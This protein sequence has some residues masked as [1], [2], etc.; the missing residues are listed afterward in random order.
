MNEETQSQTNSLTNTISRD[1][2]INVLV[3]DDDH[4][5]RWLT[6]YLLEQNNYTV[7]TATNGAEAV[8]AIKQERFDLVLMDVQMPVMDGLTATHIIR[9]NEQQTGTHVPIIAFSSGA[10]AANAQQ[11]WDAGMD[12]Y[13]AKPI[14]LDEFFRTIDAVLA[15]HALP[16]QKAS[17][18]PTFELVEALQRADNDVTLLQ[19]VAEQFLDKIPHLV[20][21]LQHAIAIEDSKELHVAAHRL[22]N[23]A[24]D[25][26]AY[27]VVELAKRLELI[28]R[29]RKMTQ[30]GNILT[31]LEQELAQFNQEFAK[32]MQK[33]SGGS[34]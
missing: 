13:M 10:S 22:S 21:A 27:G 29:V 3:V 14:H 31:A 6:S 5:N 2:W 12:S 34:Q 17:L 15:L 20:A 33:L 8:T 24:S 19:Q 1:S 18:P 32:A 9:Q 11:Y 28:S 30:A 23:F 26:S 7:S 25:L 16:S 4:L